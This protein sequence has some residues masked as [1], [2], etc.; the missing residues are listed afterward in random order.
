M[1]DN[2]YCYPPEYT[3]LKNKLDIRDAELLDKVERKIV[4]IRIEQGPP[5]GD[6]D[7][8]HLK[9]IHLHLFQD[10]Y[11]W[12]GEIRTVE[13]S[14]DG[15][16][17]QLM[18]FIETGMADVHRRIVENHYLQ[19]LHPAEFAQKAGEIIGDLNYVHPFREGNGRTQL[20]YLDQLAEQA[21]YKLEVIRI[22]PAHWLQA[23]R[24]AHNNDYRLMIHC[25]EHAIAKEQK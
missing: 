7:L 1:S 16:Q 18:K 21:G 11:A 13:I 4:S 14:K 22:Q 9:A 2:Q 25:I 8:N 17:F 19:E 12:A 20:Q 10:I 6:F 5:H 3:V 24:E 15:H 23:S